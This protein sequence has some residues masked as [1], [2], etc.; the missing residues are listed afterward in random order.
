MKIL[1]DYKVVLVLPNGDR[2]NITEFVQSLSWD[3]SQ[4]QIA[5]RAN[6]D[7]IN[8][9]LGGANI[10]QKIKLGTRMLIQYREDNK[11]V[12][13]MR[14]IVW[15]FDDRR[16]ASA[17]SISLTLYN[18]LKYLQQ[19][20]EEF[21]FPKGSKTIS[22][23]K[24]INARCGIKN[25]YQYKN[26]TKH[27]KKVFRG[28]HPSEAL[29]STLNFAKKMGDDKEKNNYVVYGSKGKC[30]IDDVGYNKKV[31]VFRPEHVTSVNNHVSM[32]G[33]VTRVVVRS[34]KNDKKRS[35]FVTKISGKTEYGIIKKIVYQS[36]DTKEKQAKKSA[37][38]VLD[39]SGRLDRSIT[40][41]TMDVP[42]IRK[43]YKIRVVKVGMLTGYYRVVS[44]THNADN[45]EMTLEIKKL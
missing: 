27:N 24:K 32:E 34:Q 12:E 37:Q 26:K 19:T 44:V 15:A 4:E 30:V 6:I 1:N 14:G 5:Q 31:Y 7:I 35:S 20:E 33:L 36:G 22:I 2:F 38:K 39:D 40:L 11:W 23:C 9:K 16:D 45:R 25:S 8:G 21:L 43:G 17:K 41:N 3:E 18:N 10:K 29:L 28:V 42:E 13:I